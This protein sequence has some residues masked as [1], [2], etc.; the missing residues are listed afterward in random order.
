M[1]QDLYVVAILTAKP[2][3]ADDLRALLLPAVEAFRQEDGCSAYALHEDTERPGRFVSYEVW[4][5]RG[6]LDQHMTSPTMREATQKL[7]D[8][9]EKE[10]EQYLLE[11][12]LQL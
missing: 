11:L 5:D 1:T 2:G 8:L 7:K 12:L 10:M 6:A 4:R 3:K 9:L